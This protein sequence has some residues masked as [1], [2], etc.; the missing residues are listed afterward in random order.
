M[1][2]VGEK[3]FRSL[4]TESLNE[5]LKLQSIIGR[6]LIVSKET[7]NFPSSGTRKM[8]SVQFSELQF[9]VEGRLISDPY[10][11][12]NPREGSSVSIVKILF[13]KKIKQS[14]YCYFVLNV[15]LNHSISEQY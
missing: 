13:K 14:V 7:L 9:A 12:F 4:T 15:I 1:V 5:L 8:K 11:E 6:C 2:D 10:F 3:P